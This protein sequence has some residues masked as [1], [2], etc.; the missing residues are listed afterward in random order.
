MSHAPLAVLGGGNMSGAIYRGAVEAGRLDPQRVVVAEPLAERRAA[1]GQAVESSREALARLEELERAAGT[2]GQVLLAVKPQNLEDVGK[3][4]A[5]KIGDRV[6]VSILAGTPSER[7]RAA[8]GGACRVVRVMPNTPA[9]IGRG[10]SAVAVGAAAVEADASLATELFQSVGKVVRIEEELM[11]AFTAVAGSGPAYVFL[12]AE[13]MADAAM[14]LG[15]PTDAADL[16]VRETIAGAGLLMA[17]EGATP[18]ELR[19][20][21]T[22]PGGTTE[23]AVLAFE[24]AGLR[25]LVARALRAARDRGRELAG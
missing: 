24:A 12:L 3:E 19:R 10:M 13:A 6:V 4:V 5:G 11:D 21:V 20:A 14:S 17:Q 23:A 22:S 8:L 1:F 16:A 2:A 25:D 9:R 7:V 18:A 15:L